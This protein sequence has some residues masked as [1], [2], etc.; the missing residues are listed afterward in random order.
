ML[1]VHEDAVHVL[2]SK[3]GQALQFAP[4][5][6]QNDKRIV[7]AAIKSYAR[8]LMWASDG[9]RADAEVVLVA[10]KIKHSTYETMEVQCK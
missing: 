4:C 10:V 5:D 6:F 9:M 1:R 3:N 7:L 2:V 8:A